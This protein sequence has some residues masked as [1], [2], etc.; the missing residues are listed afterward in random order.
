M[1][2]FEN[3][4]RNSQFINFLASMPYENSFLDLEVWQQREVISFF[5]NEELASTSAHNLIVNNILNNIEYTWSNLSIIDEAII[6]RQLRLAGYEIICYGLNTFPNSVADI[7]LILKKVEISPHETPAVKL[8]YINKLVTTV[9]DYQYLIMTIFLIAMLYIG[10]LSIISGFVIAYVV[11]A[12]LSFFMHEYA[13]HNSRC[14][15]SAETILIRS[16]FNW[17]VHILAYLYHPSLPR[18]T[19][20]YDIRSHIVHHKVW[21]TDVDGIMGSIK[22]NWFKHL[23]NPP[24]HAAKKNS[25]E[26]INNIGISLYKSKWKFNDFLVDNRIYILSI[27]HLMIIL[28]FGFT[29][30]ISYF[31]F[32]IWYFVIIVSATSD[33]FFH[34]PNRKI[35][36]DGPWWTVPIWF[37]LTY[38]IS[39]HAKPNILYFGKG[40]VKYI[41]LQYWIF[42]LA[43]TTNRTNS[44]K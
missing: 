34:S 13:Q 43:Y 19:A 41:N 6:Q 39:H 33:F 12:I 17:L 37:N 8:N 9:V 24:L 3:L 5:N 15:Q 4:L 36:K 1:L 11:T 14:S 30:Y 25:M 38:H 16:W 44:K 32:P 23:C 2:T 7:D 20:P 27:I 35:P 22:E 28:L 31:I 10:Y 21:K 26:L 42:L 40:W 18:S 29:A